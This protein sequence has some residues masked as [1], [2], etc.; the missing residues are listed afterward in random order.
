MKKNCMYLKQSHALLDIKTYFFRVVL[1]ERCLEIIASSS[2]NIP[3]YI[4]E[5]KNYQFRHQLK[6]ANETSVKMIPN[7]KE[8]NEPI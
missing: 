6:E 2:A 5:E 1:G 3:R 7:W 8:T 4:L